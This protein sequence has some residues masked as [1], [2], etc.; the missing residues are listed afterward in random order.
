[1]DHVG[2]TFLTITTGLDYTM[3]VVTAQ[4]D[5]GPAGCL[6]GFSTQSSIDPPRFLVCLSDRTAR[7]G[8]RCGPRRLASTS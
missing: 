4:A 7:C 3:V 6:V 8:L 1:M 2:E 5:A